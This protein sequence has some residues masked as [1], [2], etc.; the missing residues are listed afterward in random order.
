MKKSLFILMFTSL[1][2]LS[3]CSFINKKVQ[4]EVTPLDMND[5]HSISDETMMK[6]DMD[7]EWTKEE[8]EQM[9][10]HD[11]NMESD[12]MMNDSELGYWD[13]SLDKLSTTKNNVLFF[14]ASWCPT[15]QATDK[16]LKSEIIPDD[17]NILKVD[18]D[19]YTD[20]KKKYWITM[21]H[22][23]VLVDSSWN[24]IKKWSGTKTSQEIEEKVNSWNMND[25]HS[26]SEESMNKKEDNNKMW[27]VYWDYSVEK[28]SSTKNNVLFFAASWCPTCQATD[29]NL[30]SEIIPDDLNILKVDYDNYTE[31]KK[32]YWITTQHSFVLVDSEW[33]MIKKW[34]WT[35]TVEKIEKQIN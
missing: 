27:G 13:Y 11:S 2:I 17:L 31:L 23:F 18:Y 20:L 6:D 29:K 15:C 19:N 35:D 25:N 14:A 9:W 10:M 7:W 12:S 16:N 1:L 3:S 5:N 33:N 30:K 4:E 8:M 32:K 24:M 26:V 22:T 21:Q 34:S 28:L